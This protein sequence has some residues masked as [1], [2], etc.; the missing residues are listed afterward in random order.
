MTEQQTVQIIIREC[1]GWSWSVPLANT[2]DSNTRH[3]TL[4]NEKKLLFSLIYY[5]LTKMKI[6]IEQKIKLFLF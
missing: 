3:K 5:L 2:R 4:K 6:Y 1:A